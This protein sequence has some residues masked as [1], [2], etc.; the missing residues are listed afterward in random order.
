MFVP[1]ENIAQP[2]DGGASG[3]GDDLG[4]RPRKGHQGAAREA[5][6]HRRLS[7]AVGVPPGARAELPGDQRDQRAADQ[8]RDRT[9]PGG[10]LLRSVDVAQRPHA[11]AAAVAGL[12]LFVVHLGNVGEI[13]RQG[14]PQ[15]KATP[16][17]QFD[18]SPEVFLVYGR[19]DL[20][21]GD[22]R[23]LEDE[24]HVAG[25]RGGDLRLERESRRP[26]LI[27]S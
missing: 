23:Q 4:S 9:Q 16:L 13:Y 3:R 18:P 6:P 27:R 12:Q 2:L 7:A 10:D 22:Q 14:V 24:L 19:G 11:A 15:V 25:R 17:N 21:P 5:D 1:A 20:W 26:M 8:L